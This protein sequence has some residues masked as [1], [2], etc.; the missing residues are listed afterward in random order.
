MEPGT[1]ARDIFEILSRRAT[2]RNFRPDP[3]PDDV[4]E[5]LLGA[6]CSSA[7]AGGFQRISV[8]LVRDEARK[9]RLAQLSRNQGFVAKAPANFVFCVDYRRMQRIAEHEISPCAESNSIGSL[10]VGVIDATIAAQSVALAAEGLGLRSCY[11]G[12]VLD[13]PRQLTELL[14]LPL[15][16]APAIMLTVGYPASSV[17]RPSRKYAPRVMTHDEV[18]RDLPIAELCAAHAE[19]F[20]ETYSLN[21]ERR[22]SLRRAAEAQSGAS[23]AQRCLEKADAAGKLTAYQFWFGCFYYDESRPEASAAEYLDYLAGQ[24]FDI[25]GNSD[26]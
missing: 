25:T 14:E 23:F 8:I 3:I 20:P 6:A 21:A 1:R 22:E 11:N 19:K 16:V 17:S 26:G 5:K 13:L 2:C 9:K 10:M 15:G 4:M 12:N 7:S 18:Y 24:G